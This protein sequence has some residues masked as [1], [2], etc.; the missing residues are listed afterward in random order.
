M[1]NY[2]IMRIEKRKLGT[3]GG[4]AIDYTKLIADANARGDFTAVAYYTRL[5]GQNK[6]N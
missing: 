3:V 4:S 2:A 1:A 6:T 5:Q